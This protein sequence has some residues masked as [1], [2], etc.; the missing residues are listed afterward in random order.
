V[1]DLLL[2]LAQLGLHRGLAL[3]HEPLQAFNIIG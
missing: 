2:F 3:D 1:L